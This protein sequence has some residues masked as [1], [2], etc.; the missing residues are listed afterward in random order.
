ML[1]ENR[2][3][4][5]VSTKLGQIEKFSQK[6]KNRSREEIIYT[7]VKICVPGTLKTH[8]MFK[9]NLSFTQLKQMVS[10]LEQECLIEKKEVV[11]GETIHLVFFATK[12]G[13]DYL[14]HYEKLSAL[15]SLETISG[16]AKEN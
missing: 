6:R 4:V 14:S 9:G 12:R 3:I 15:L 13:L 5:S 1:T 16:I 2:K 10:Y 11:I 8:L 7:L